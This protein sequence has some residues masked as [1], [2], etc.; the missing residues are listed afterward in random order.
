M[1]VIQTNDAEADIFPA[2]VETNR[3]ALSLETDDDWMGLLQDISNDSDDETIDITNVMAILAS[4][5]NSS[6][7]VNLEVKMDL[8]ER[9]LVNYTMC[10]KC[11]V[12]GTV[13]DGLIRCEKCGLEMPIIDDNDKFSFASDKDHNVSSNSFMSFNIVG[14]NSYCYQR[15][16]LKTCSN[17]S[18]FRRNNNRKEMY[19]YN[20]QH[21]GKKIPKNAIKL[22]IEL[23]SQIKEKGYVFRGNGKKGVLGAC[24][25]YACVM[26]N[27]TKTPREIA[28]IMDIE[29][30]FLSQGDR[31]VQE[32][33]EAGVIKIPTTLRPMRD[34][35][36]QHFPSL[37]IPD[38]YKLFVMDV[39]E[40]AEKKN[41]HIQNDS[42]TTTKC[43]GAIWLLVNRVR[44]LK[45]ITK[46]NI[47]KECD[48]S[49]STFVRYYNLLLNNSAILK[50]IFKNHRIPMPDNWKSVESDKP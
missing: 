45:A 32:L 9:K 19:N 21:E 7:S 41:I 16:F 15:S 35:L 5:G 37:G 6:N 39:I 43:I 31:K 11:E 34:Y 8:G 44:E 25:F 24:L 42:R 10:P 20:Y 48:I 27:I 33:N 12:E 18:S 23:F 17:Y 46:D 4:D 22:A 3:V 38:K 50:P 28:S 13:S 40:R 14:K 29:D 26:N 2:N 49:R 36:D 47:V 1:S 30:R